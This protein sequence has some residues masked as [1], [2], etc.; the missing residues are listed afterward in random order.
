MRRVLSTLIVF[1]TF[2]V[3]ALTA[4]TTSTP[5]EHAHWLDVLHKL[6]AEPLAPANVSEGEHVFKRL[7]EV[8]DFHMTI[9]PIISELPQKYSHAQPIMQLFTIGLAGY[10]LETGKTDSEGSNLYALHSV[11]KGYASILAADPKAHD[12]K[13]DDLVKLDAD[14]KLPDLVRKKGCKNS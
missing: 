1:A 5:E 3:P 12:K 8:T 4:Q 2:L 6:Q 9:C 13:L 14:G 7:V 10:Q 11:L